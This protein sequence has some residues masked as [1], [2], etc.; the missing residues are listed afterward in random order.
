MDGQMEKEQ[1]YK[2]DYS[3]HANY[4]YCLLSLMSRWTI[5]PDFGS[6]AGFAAFKIPAVP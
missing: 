2:H 4:G 6:A 5:N 3:R 1:R